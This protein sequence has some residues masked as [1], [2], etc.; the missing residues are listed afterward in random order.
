[1]L[2][3]RLLA[4]QA[5]LLLAD[6][7]PNFEEAANLLM[8]AESHLIGRKLPDL[9]ALTAELRE[10][11]SRSGPGTPGPPALVA[12]P[13][14]SAPGVT[15]GP[16]LRR[17]EANGKVPRPPLEAAGG[18]GVLVGNSPSI[19]R[20]I[21]QIHQAAPSRLP[22]LITGET[23]AGKELVAVAIHRESLRRS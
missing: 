17:G 21:G 2:S 22:V 6:A 23:G 13:G 11:L 3:A 8:E 9:E 4:Y 7:H 14:G 18:A 20:L 5:K 15:D 16:V 10:R 19:R 12:T 1:M